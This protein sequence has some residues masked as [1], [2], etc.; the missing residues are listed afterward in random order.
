MGKKTENW[1]FAALDKKVFAFPTRE[2]RNFWIYTM[3]LTPLNKIQ[4]KYWATPQDIREAKK[5]WPN[6]LSDSE[7]QKF[8]RRKL[9]EIDR[10]YVKLRR[11]RSLISRVTGSDLKKTAKLAR[12][13][14]FG[15]DRMP[16]R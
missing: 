15:D 9:R 8:Y 6:N 5:S 16:R 4:L 12:M 2:E 10:E 3:G 1:F 11:V 7:L 14:V 13:E